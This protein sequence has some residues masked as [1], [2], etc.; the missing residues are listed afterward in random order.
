MSGY[1]MTDYPQITVSIGRAY[2]HAAKSPKRGV[3]WY[4]RPMS[5]EMW[6]RYRTEVFSILIGA[7]G[8]AVAL[9]TDGVSLWQDEDGLVWEHSYTVAVVGIA[10]AHHANI[11]R[12]LAEVAA[13]YQQDSIAVTV[14]DPSFIPA[15]KG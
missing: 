9:T 14:A 4:G 12:Q 5:A 8:G 7:P 13:E 6:R 11:R 10:P 2:G 3:S 1:P 15:K